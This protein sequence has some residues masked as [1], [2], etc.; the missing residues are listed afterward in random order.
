M[1]TVKFHYIYEG[2]E[3]ILGPVKAFLYSSNGE[4][5][6]WDYDVMYDFHEIQV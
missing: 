2:R 3:T 1:N 4:F 5:E 6:E